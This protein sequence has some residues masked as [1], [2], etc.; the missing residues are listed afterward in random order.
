[1]LNS[2]GFSFDENGAA[3]G[4]THLLAD[5]L[6][7]FR[8]CARKA[9][10]G[11]RDLLSEWLGGVEES[12]PWMPGMLAVKPNEDGVQ[13]LHTVAA[14]LW[15]VIL[16]ELAGRAP[17]VVRVLSPFYDNDL[18]LAARMRGAW[19]GC[20]LEIT[21]QQH[22]SGVPL[23][24][25]LALGP[26]VTLHELRGAGSRRLHAK[27]CAFEH[28]KGTFFIAGSAN[29][30]TAAFDGRN[31]ETCLA[32]HDQETRFDDLF[33]NKITRRLIAAENFDSSGETPPELRP[34]TAGSGWQ[35]HS[36]VLA[37]SDRLRFEF[38]VPPRATGELSAHLFVE[39]EIRPVLA[40]AVAAN[41]RGSGESQLTEKQSALLQ[42]PVRCELRLG[43]YVTGRSWLVQEARLTHDMG[44]GGDR[45]TERERLIH[46]TGAGLLEKLAEIAHTE[47]HLAALEYLARLNI[48]FMDVAAQV[49]RR[50]AVK[51]HDP[52]R[53]DEL[54]SWLLLPPELLRD[55]GAA[56]IEFIE[57][58]EHNIFRR[59]ARRPSLGGLANFQDVMLAVA[60]LLCD[61]FAKGALDF[62]RVVGFLCDAVQIFGFGIESETKGSPGY[63]AGLLENL[64][65][66]RSE[67]VDAFREHN[68]LAVLRVVLLT[69][70]RA[71]AGCTRETP[72]HHTRSGQRTKNS[73]GSCPRSA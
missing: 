67:I 47:G 10:E 4:Q 69:A 48:R 29:F 8:A 9:P 35:I 16:S 32:W 59:H 34:R 24:A 17:R 71:R 72:A 22:T 7:F 58:H 37:K 40:V 18:A 21:A 44:G 23:N 63:T 30:T 36:A 56:V 12:M 65:S 60:R 55:Y 49:G 27:L 46:E 42:G 25:L 33:A 20:R 50:F 45:A 3:A 19:P 6:A 31:V 15:S 5:A 43:A 52:F 1:L 13:L 54:P 73:R 14:D 39:N 2:F 68:T 61:T 66:S 41:A 57:R 38:S 64:A 26:K 53:R 11:L 28:A 70:Q 62:S 51:A